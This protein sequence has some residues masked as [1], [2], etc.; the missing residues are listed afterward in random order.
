MPY[1]YIL[2]C[3]DDSYYVGQTYDVELRVA[4]HKDGTFEG[5]TSARRPVT[6]VWHE[7]VQTGNQAFQLERK[8]KGWSRA[9]KEALIAGDYEQIHDIVRNERKTREARKRNYSTCSFVQTK[10]STKC[11][12]RS[13]QPFSVFVKQYAGRL[14]EVKCHIPNRTR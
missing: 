11:D 10:Y 1:V 14:D 7:F 5:Y 2:K 12:T 8:L 4:Q 3:A 9:K 6:L 13:I